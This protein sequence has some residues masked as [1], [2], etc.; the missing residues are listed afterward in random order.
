[1]KES[2]RLRAIA[3]S[4]ENWAKGK[5]KSHKPDK[6]CTWNLTRPFMGPKKEN[7]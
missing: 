1:M 4:N 6:N 2:E 7:T 5:T 3:K